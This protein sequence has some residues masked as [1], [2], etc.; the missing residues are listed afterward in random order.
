MVLPRRATFALAL[1]LLLWACSFG[2]GPTAD[3]NKVLR[4]GG[5]ALGQVKTAGVELK[6]G[7]GATFFG[8]TVVSASGKVQPK[9]LVKISAEWFHNPARLLEEEPK[10]V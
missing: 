2:G 7:S 3:P 10:N 8:F 1:P 6:F 4:D 9:R 5:T